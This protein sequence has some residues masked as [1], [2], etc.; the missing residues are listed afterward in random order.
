MIPLPMVVLHILVDEP[1]QVALPG[2]NDFAVA[3][4]KTVTVDASRART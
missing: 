2:K 4:G 3:V 1:A